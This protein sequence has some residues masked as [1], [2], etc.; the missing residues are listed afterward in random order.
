MSDW[1]PATE[2]V[3]DDEVDVLLVTDNP[4]TGVWIGYRLEGLWIWDCGGAIQD[5][6]THWMPLPE[7]PK[8]T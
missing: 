4:N 5:T 1:I 2:R 3:P 8:E 7:R 6:V